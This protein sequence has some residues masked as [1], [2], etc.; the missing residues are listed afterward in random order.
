MI[1]CVTGIM[2]GCLP[3][4]LLIYKRLALDVPKSLQYDTLRTVNC[5]VIK[6]KE[7]FETTAPVSTMERTM[8]YA[9]TL[10]TF[11]KIS[12][13]RVKSVDPVVFFA[14]GSSKMSHI[15]E[16]C[17]SALQWEWEELVCQ[18]MTRQGD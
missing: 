3:E 1:T 13:P 7:S 4:P 10:A 2:S 8:T 5:E 9:Q 12:M 18:W 14:G 17:G 6:I 15:F 16:S 11:R